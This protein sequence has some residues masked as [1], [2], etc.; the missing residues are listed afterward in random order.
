MQITYVSTVTRCLSKTLCIETVT[1]TCFMYINMEVLYVSVRTWHKTNVTL[2]PNAYYIC[3]NWS[4]GWL[5]NGLR[6]AVY[7]TGEH[8]DDNKIWSTQSLNTGSTKYNTKYWDA[9]C[10]VC[11][12]CQQIYCQAHAC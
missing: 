12:T 4:V 9:G 6:S 1:Y 8:K 2:K 5:L 7:I 3:C 10:N 11:V